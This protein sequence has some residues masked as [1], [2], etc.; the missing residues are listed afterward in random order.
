ML[1]IYLQDKSPQIFR[2][3]VTPD[4]TIQSRLDEKIK[5]AVEKGHKHVGGH[6]HIVKTRLIQTKLEA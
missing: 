6:H 1:S 3:R 4:P 5:E 2:P